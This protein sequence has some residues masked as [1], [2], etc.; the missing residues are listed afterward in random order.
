MD[1]VSIPVFLS[2]WEPLIDVGTTEY[3]KLDGVVRAVIEDYLT[4][5]RLPP[6]PF[7][8]IPRPFSGARI[9]LA[10]VEELCAPLGPVL[11]RWQKTFPT[12]L[13]SSYGAGWFGFPGAER[14]IILIL[15]DV[16]ILHLP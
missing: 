8:L 10:N 2:N 6:S 1:F 11:Q 15:E 16:E 3:G 12:R 4:S 9:A 14:H 13:G 5:P 7:L